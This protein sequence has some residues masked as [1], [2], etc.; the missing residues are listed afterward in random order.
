VKK[1]KRSG[2]DLFITILADIRN[3]LAG[4]HFSKDKKQKKGL[5]DHYSPS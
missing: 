3:I 1:K 5:P 4:E 2:N